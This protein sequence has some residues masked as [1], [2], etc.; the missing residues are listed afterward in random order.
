MYNFISWLIGGWVSCSLV[1][2]YLII[3]AP[4]REDYDE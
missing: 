3:K 2:T 4:I 1:M